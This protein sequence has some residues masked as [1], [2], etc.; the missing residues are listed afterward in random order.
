MYKYNL[1]LG[2]A[3]LF[4]SIIKIKSYIANKSNKHYNAY[5]ND[6]TRSKSFTIMT[7]NIYIEG[8]SKLWHIYT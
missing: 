4:L 6:S 7:N 8:D 3:P 2:L 5:T 1:E